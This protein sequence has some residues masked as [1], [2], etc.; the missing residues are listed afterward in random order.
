MHALI[1]FGRFSYLFWTD[2]A[3]APLAFRRSR[4][5]NLDFLSTSSRVSVTKIGTFPTVCSGALD[6]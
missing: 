4:I 6:R 2:R 5:A 1:T 3:L